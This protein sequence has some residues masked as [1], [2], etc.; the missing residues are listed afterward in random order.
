MMTMPILK[1]TTPLAVFYSLQNTTSENRSKDRTLMDFKRT[2]SHQETDRRLEMQA[3]EEMELFPF[4]QKA[5]KVEAA[6]KD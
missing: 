5:T 6:R 3:M 4:P 2:Q 1:L